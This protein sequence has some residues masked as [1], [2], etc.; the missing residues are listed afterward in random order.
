MTGYVTPVRPDQAFSNQKELRIPNREVASIFQDV[1]VD[2][3]KKSVDE[4]QL[5][6]LMNALWN[7]NEALATEI[8][9]D[10]LWSTISYFDY[11]EDYYHA[12]LAGIF[13]RRGKYAVNSNKE[14]GLGRPDIELKDRRNRRCL[15]IEAK[16]SKSDKDMEKDCELAIKQINEDQYALNLNGYRKVL[17]YGIAFYQKQALV[18]LDRS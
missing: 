2:H 13:V 1:V 10:L 12:F 5:H 4:T 11:K 15:I 16:H 18:K 8:I 7:E 3:F 9:S 6:D 14:H 17:R